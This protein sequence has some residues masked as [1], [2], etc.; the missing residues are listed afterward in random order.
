MI[1]V[2]RPILGRLFGAAGL[3]VG[4]SIVSELLMQLGRNRD[5]KLDRRPVAQL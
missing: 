3:A 4:N 2:Q 5:H 1:S